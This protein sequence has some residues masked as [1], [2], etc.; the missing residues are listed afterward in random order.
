MFMKLFNRQGN[1][2]KKFK[3]LA[4]SLHLRLKWCKLI[5]YDEN[6]LFAG[7]LCLVYTTNFFLLFYSSSSYQWKEWERIKYWI[8]NSWM[9]SC[10]CQM[11]DYF[12]LFF[13][14]HLFLCKVVRCR[15]EVT[16][17]HIFVLLASWV[18]MWVRKF[19][20]ISSWRWDLHKSLIEK[21]FVFNIRS[22]GK[23]L[24]LSKCLHTKALCSVIV[25]S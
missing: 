16:K 6:I 13:H 22:D 11:M 21:F 12:F 1:E 5:L 20:H 17:V 8:T 25:S 14:H 15:A 2:E 3:I 9:K 19:L 24:I 18:N 10:F 23:E 4:K 7:F